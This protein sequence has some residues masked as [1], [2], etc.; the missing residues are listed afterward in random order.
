MMG[1]GSHKS[2]DLQLANS[3]LLETSLQENGH[4]NSFSLL[5]LTVTSA[6]SPHNRYIQIPR[7]LSCT[8][9][10]N[11]SIDSWILQLCSC[12]LFSPW[13][14]KTKALARR[15]WMMS[16][17]KDLPPFPFQ[18]TALGYWFL[19]S[20]RVFCLPKVFRLML[21]IKLGSK[22]E[23]KCRSFLNFK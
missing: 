7:C 3:K 12:H 6:I 5:N 1:K 22:N 15:G 8:I 19:K 21:G 11:L 16:R 13:Q 10:C 17:P 18:R 14:K 2:I 4:K 23:K 20:T 9:L